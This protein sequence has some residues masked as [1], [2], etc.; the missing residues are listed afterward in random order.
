MEYEI[1][2]IID[3]DGSNIHWELAHENLEHSA[4]FNSKEDAQMY[5][6]EMSET[7]KNGFYQHMRKETRSDKFV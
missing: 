2:E 6:D 4:I 1:K 5:A 7:Y 3:I